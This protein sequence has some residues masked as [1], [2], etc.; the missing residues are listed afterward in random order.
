MGGGLKCLTIMLNG[1][2]LL[3]VEFSYTSVPE[4]EIKQH[5]NV[6]NN[7]PNGLKNCTLHLVLFRG[8]DL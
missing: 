3:L 6:E 1:W 5:N 7:V 4:G 2:T 8:L